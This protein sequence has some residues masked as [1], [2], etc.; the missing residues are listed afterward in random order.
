VELRNGAPAD[1]GS[2]GKRSN[3]EAGVS[4]EYTK[5]EQKRS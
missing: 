4:P 3:N 2:V 5:D 1:Q